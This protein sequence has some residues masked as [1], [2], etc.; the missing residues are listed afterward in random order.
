M[1][2]IT[3]HPGDCIIFN[4]SSVRRLKG[5]DLSVAAETWKHENDYPLIVRLMLGGSKGGW[6][7]G[8]WGYKEV[9]RSPIIMNAQM[10]SLNGKVVHLMMRQWTRRKSDPITRQFCLSFTS[11]DLAESFVFAHNRFLLRKEKMEAH[12]E[13][14]NAA[15]ASEV[16]GDKD[17]EDSSAG[18]DECSG[19]FDQDESG[20]DAWEG[21]V[22]DEAEESHWLDS[23]PNTQDPFSDY[24]SD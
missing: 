15:A 11:E 2:L 23:M 1:S 18:G 9:F 20:E 14:Q 24:I 17:D 16:G 4:L 10:N 7:M 8:H 6:M 5:N 19:S 21:K 3:Y 12:T 13:Q 22:L